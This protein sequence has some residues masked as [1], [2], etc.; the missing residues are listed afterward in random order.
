[1]SRPASLIPWDSNG[2]NSTQPPGGY[3]TDGWTLGDAAVSA[4]DNYMKSH[5]CDWLGHLRDYTISLALSSWAEVATSGAI[6]HASGDFDHEQN[7]LVCDG[8]N[9]HYSVDGGQTWTS[10]GYSNDIVAHDRAGVWLGYIGA[11][12][13]AK[14]TA[15]PTSAGAWS[16][17]ATGATSINTQIGYVCVCDDLKHLNGAWWLVGYGST[18]GNPG[19]VLKSVDDGAT[20]A[21]ETGYNTSSSRLKGISYG[22]GVLVV[23]GYITTGP[24]GEAAY[25]T[26]NGVTWTAGSVAGSPTQFNA[27]DYGAGVFVAVG[28]GGEIQYSSNGA[29]W[30][31]A[32]AD[33][34]YSSGF[35]DVRFEFGVFVAVGDGGEVQTSFDGITWKRR[36]SSTTDDLLSVAIDPANG[37]AIAGKTGKVQI[38]LDV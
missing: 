34:G 28:E 38:S 33:A 29:T 23:V 3:Q 20:W 15:A 27:V 6:A 1:M 14:A 37:Q 16:L 26:D 18:T 21:R 11:N 7:A 12:D 4:Y 17:V 13:V 25:S 5:F 19:V 2:T 31:Q 32:T 22:G 10:Y 9:C 30:A 24:T 36:A 8:T 35:N